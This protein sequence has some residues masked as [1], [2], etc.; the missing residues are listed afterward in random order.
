MREKVGRRS[1]T[2]SPW[3]S[4][5]ER[6]IVMLPFVTAIVGHLLCLTRP[7]PFITG[8][9]VQEGTAGAGFGTSQVL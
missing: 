2:W 3:H 1:H 9:Y 5:A 4:V 7:L 6:I 8:E